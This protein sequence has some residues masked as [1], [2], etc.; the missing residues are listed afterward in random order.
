MESFIA[1][2]MMFGGNFAPRNWAICNGQLLA[3]STN[4]ALFSLIGTIYGGD[5]R[6]TFALPDL[7]GR[8]PIGFGTGPGLPSYNQGVHVGSTSHSLN[9][10]ELTNHTHTASVSGLTVSGTVNVTTESADGN[11]PTDAYLA[12]TAG[13]H[14]IYNTTRTGTATLASDAISVSGSGGSVTVV[15][16]GNSQ[17]F[18]LLQPSIAMNYIICLQ[19]IFPSRN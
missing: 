4:T 2:I 17:A 5:G 1:A 19:G 3:I 7:R 14:R 9:L 15:P 16:T 13:A 11:D 18:S 12:T 10:N 8:V 6:T